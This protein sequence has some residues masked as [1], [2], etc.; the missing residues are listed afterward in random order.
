MTPLSV[1]RIWGLGIFSWALLGLG[2]YLAVEAYDEFTRPEFVVVA[3]EPAIVDDTAPV[4]AQ[5]PAAARANGVVDADAAEPSDRRPAE[6]HVV[7]ADDQ[8]KRWALLAGAVACLGLSLVGYWPINWM[9]GGTKKKPIVDV[10]PSRTMN[11]DRPDGTRLH[12][13]VFGDANR[14][15]LL[16][17]HGWSL[18]SSAWKYIMG[19]LLDRYRIVT[20]DLPGLGR[21]RGPANKD[22]SLEKMAHDLHAVLQATAEQGSP[23]ILVGHS[24][25]GMIL[26]V[27]SR[28]HQA[29]LDRTV[30]GLA[31]IHTTYTNPLRTITASP[32][33]TALETPLIIPLNYLTIGLS[34][35]AWL[36]NW[37]SYLN[38]SLHLSTRLISFSG[39]QSREQ[40]DHGARLAAVAW[41]ATIARGNLAMFKFDEQATLAHVQVPVLVVA[42]DHDRVTLPSASQHIERLLPNDRA[43][44]IDGGHLGYWEVSEQAVELV[45]E[46]ADQVTA[47]NRSTYASQLAPGQLNV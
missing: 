33:A 39:K 15:T 45:R 34:A 18:D 35:L 32:L 7:R 38:G 30:K 42:G 13:E 31:L 37:Q 5:A 1:L 19:G 12:V 11:V 29:E 14:P 47:A 21:S 4:P 10:A 22:Y 25:G 27:F 24:I 20:W 16:L 2:I 46:F 40:I 41:P 36:S 44:H 3:R 6:R 43:T 17:T 8:W 26:Q 28:V 9:L 23:V